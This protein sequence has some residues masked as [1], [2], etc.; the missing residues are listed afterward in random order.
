MGVS[1]Y[2]YSS[3]ASGRRCSSPQEA[4]ISGFIEDEQFLMLMFKPSISMILMF[5]LLFGNLI[6]IFI[7]FFKGPRGGYSTLWTSSF[8]ELVPD[9]FANINYVIF[10][11]KKMLTYYYTKYRYF[12]IIKL[13]SSDVLYLCL[14]RR[15]VGIRVF[16]YV[17]LQIY[18]FYQCT[19]TNLDL[20]FPL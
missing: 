3:R 15:A 9:W 14:P 13:I 16:M 19:N 8:Y 4:W 17:C 20:S 5:G 12:N 6:I 1:K 7:I 18:L 11:R 2:L 10:Y